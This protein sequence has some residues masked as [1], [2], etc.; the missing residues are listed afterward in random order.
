MNKI[1][2]FDELKLLVYKFKSNLNMRENY[3]KEIKAD[4]EKLHGKDSW[5]GDNPGGCFG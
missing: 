1:N 4:M 3:T 2:S 5:E